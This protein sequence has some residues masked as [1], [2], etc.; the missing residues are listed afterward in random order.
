M[1]AGVLCLHVHKGYI[2]SPLGN[3]FSTAR[4]T[5]MGTNWLSML[6]T[7]LGIYCETKDISVN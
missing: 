6:I 7:Q 2:G 3:V 5:L 1:L 4:G